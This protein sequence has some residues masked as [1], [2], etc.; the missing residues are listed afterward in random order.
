MTPTRHFESRRRQLLTLG[1][2]LA[3]GLLASLVPLA[4]QQ[5]IEVGCGAAQLVRTGVKV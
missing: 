2:G 1:A 4:G 3:C 5:I